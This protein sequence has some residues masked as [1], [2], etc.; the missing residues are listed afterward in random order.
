[1]S[2]DSARVVVITTSSL[3]SVGMVMS[4]HH[5]DVTNS[6][7]VRDAPR[8]ADL[9][10]IDVSDTGAA[11]SMVE[12]YRAARAALADVGPGELP[13]II[14][15]AREPVEDLP[16]NV[17]F[18][19]RPYTVDRLVG[20]IETMLTAEPAAPNPSSTSPTARATPA[21]AQDDRVEPEDVGVLEVVDS[22]AGDTSGSGPPEDAESAALLDAPP[23]RPL[24]DGPTQSPAAQPPH[25]V[26]DPAITRMPSDEPSTAVPSEPSRLWRWLGGQRRRDRQG[27]REFRARVED[28]LQVV[29][30]LE[31]LVE[32]VPALTDRPALARLLVAEVERRLAADTAGLW[33]LRDDGWYAR[34][35]RGFTAHEARLV[36]APAQPLFHQVD[37]TAGAILI[38]PVEPLQHLVAG[39]GG[40]HT[41]SFMAAALT[42][43]GQGYGIIAVGRRA[44]FVARD[45][46]VLVELASEVAPLLAIADRLANLREAAPPP[47]LPKPERRSW[48]RDP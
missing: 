4:E 42:M 19:P 9:L 35:H 24:S 8:D 46:D 28:A 47:P 17:T 15:G 27:P 25:E 13:A 41:E 40:A 26:P 29:H 43:S 21:T 33:E 16:D 30:Q 34:G 31:D 18:V 7:S 22:A 44:A 32:Q 23:P 6:E 38:D 45:L 2:D 20:L 3:L 11:I 36:V 48:H 14:T 5:W 10:V 39:I 37:A 12:E 1:V